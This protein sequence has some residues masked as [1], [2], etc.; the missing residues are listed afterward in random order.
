MPSPK[1]LM[2]VFLAA[3]ER[4][5]SDAWTPAMAQAAFFTAVCVQQKG[6]G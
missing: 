5:F 2:R 1:L 6:W 4:H 3:V